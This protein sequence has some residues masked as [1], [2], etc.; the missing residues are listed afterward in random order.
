MAYTLLCNKS[1]LVKF[2]LWG[3]WFRVLFLFMLT[4]EAVVSERE[5]CFIYLFINTLSCY[6]VSATLL[7]CLQDSQSTLYKKRLNT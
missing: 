3:I 7:S 5:V 2:E 6:F 4:K 1:Y